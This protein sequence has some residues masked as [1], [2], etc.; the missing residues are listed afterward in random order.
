MGK[1]KQ[2]P[3]SDE[4]DE[5]IATGEESEVEKPVKVK[6]PKVRPPL[7]PS[8]VFILMRPF[9]SVATTKKPVFKNHDDDDEEG[10][11]AKKKKPESTVG[12]L[13]PLTQLGQ[14]HLAT[15]S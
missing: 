1:R 14:Q 15:L 12:T 6:K 4:E 11:P 10:R 8:V 9:Q 5:A 13:R 2:V 7:T 3:I